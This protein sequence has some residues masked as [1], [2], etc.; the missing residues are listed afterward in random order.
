M[1]ILSIRKRI[2]SHINILEG[3]AFLLL[4]RW[5]LRSRILVDSAVSLGAAA[6][7]RS[8]RTINHLLRKACALQL[9]EDIILYLV[10]VP[11]PA[12]SR[13]EEYVC[14]SGHHA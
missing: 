12:T 9:A 2:T 10:L 13:L 4:L 3:E 11:S 5:L 6:K 7:A 8:S 14:V 1:H